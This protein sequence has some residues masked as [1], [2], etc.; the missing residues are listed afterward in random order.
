MLHQQKKV[1]MHNK[2]FKKCERVNDAC[3]LGANRG[4]SIRGLVISLPIF[5]AGAALSG[6]LL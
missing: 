5:A 1:Q 6:Q 2:G 3:V 4:S